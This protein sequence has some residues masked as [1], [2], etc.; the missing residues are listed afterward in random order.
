MQKQNE[1]IPHSLTK[2]CS[3]KIFFFKKEKNPS[4]AFAA[5]RV[6]GG[7][8]HGKK[9]FAAPKKLKKREKKSRFTQHRQFFHTVGG[10]RTSKTSNSS[11]NNNS[12]NSSNIY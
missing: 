10:S 7:H 4:S 11:R 3:A 6:Q 9:E 5:E 2:K 8:G 1:E 12:N